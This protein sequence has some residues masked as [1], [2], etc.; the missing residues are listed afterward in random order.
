[1][2]EE[3]YSVMGNTLLQSL[4]GE[5][6][7]VGQ[8][9]LFKK[10]K[11]WDERHEHL[12]MWKNIYTVREDKS[13]YYYPI[14]HGMKKCIYEFQFG[15][16]FKVKIVFLLNESIETF[17]SDQTTFTIEMPHI[18]KNSLHVSHCSDICNKKL[19]LNFEK[20][21][22]MRQC[23]KK[24]KDLDY[25]ISSCKSSID[26]YK[27]FGFDSHQTDDILQKWQ[28][29]RFDIGL[30]GNFFHKLFCKCDEK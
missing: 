18:D 21:E 3:G 24:S 25:F 13:I 6:W 27:Q 4:L 28:N 26:F 10:V 11:S 17:L 29:E 2:E 12:R 16:S 22:S 1:V 9:I 30:I 20:Q 8:Y 19:L 5:R 23:D 14:C 7:N 15:S